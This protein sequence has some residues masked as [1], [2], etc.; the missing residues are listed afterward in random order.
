MSTITFCP[1]LTSTWLLNI[2]SALAAPLSLL[3]FLGNSAADFHGPS[4]PY[5][6]SNWDWVSPWPIHE[7][8]F[9]IWKIFPVGS[10]FSMTVTFS[11]LQS[12]SNIP[13]F[14]SILSLLLRGHSLVQ[15][16]TQFARFLAIQY[17]E[18]Y[19]QYFDINDVILYPYW[20]LKRKLYPF[21]GCINTTSCTF[22]VGKSNP[23]NWILSV[24]TKH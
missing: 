14:D 6:S 20:I 13:G 18:R 4:N 11:H 23:F 22:F 16:L 10:A 12:V 3:V 15:H 5:R 2:L 1:L 21:Q 7:C 8:Q 9:C 17:C 19:P 24:F